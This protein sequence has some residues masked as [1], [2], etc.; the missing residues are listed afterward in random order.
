MFGS[1]SGIDL[2]TN[3]CVLFIAIG[4]IVFEEE[5]GPLFSLVANSLK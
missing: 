3:D 2:E 5:I 1:S 4:F